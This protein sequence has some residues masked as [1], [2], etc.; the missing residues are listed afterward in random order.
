MNETTIMVMGQL[1]AAQAEIAAAKLDNQIR[2][3]EGHMGINLN[4]P[5]EWFNEKAE[6]VRGIV[7][8]LFR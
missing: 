8:Q 2:L 7:S 4:Y 3:S 1:I 5:P 6:E